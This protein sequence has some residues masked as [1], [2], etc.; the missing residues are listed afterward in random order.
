MNILGIRPCPPP[1]LPN[2]PP[3][4]EQARA[5]FANQTF[6]RF[7]LNLVYVFF[8]IQTDFV[9][10]TQNCAEIGS[11]MEFRPI[12]VQE[13]NDIRAELAAAGLCTMLVW[14]T[15]NGIPTLAYFIPGQPVVIV[16]TPTI[17]CSAY[18]FC[19]SNIEG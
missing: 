17:N 13:L 18:F 7:D 2:E 5:N 19:V 1:T 6:F 16:P 14:T 15:N 10:S 9:S 11:E 8:N 4:C 3:E 12:T